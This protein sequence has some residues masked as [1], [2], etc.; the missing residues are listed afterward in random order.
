[1][2]GQNHGLRHLLYQSKN[3]TFSQLLCKRVFFGPFT[4]LQLVVHDVGGWTS[5]MNKCETV[6]IYGFYFLFA[7]PLNRAS[8]PGP[9]RQRIKY[10]TKL[11][12]NNM[13][14]YF[15]NKILKVMVILMDQWRLYHIVRCRAC[16][17]T[18]WSGWLD[19]FCPSESEWG[20]LVTRGRPLQNLYDP[21]QCVCRRRPP[22]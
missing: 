12:N 18:R 6:K 14:T 17:S 7:F 16:F 8:R 9:V 15:L 21:L 5:W 4:I 3:V 10:F 19:D 13:K 11:L 1:M 20:G 22:M 2:F